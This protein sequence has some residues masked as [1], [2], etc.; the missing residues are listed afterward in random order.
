MNIPAFTQVFRSLGLLLLLLPGLGC[1]VACDDEEAPSGLV[2]CEAGAPEEW[3][4]CYEYFDKALACT[5]EVLWKYH[6]QGR[7]EVEDLPGWALPD[8]RDGHPVIDDVRAHD[9]PLGEGDAKGRLEE[10]A[11]RQGL[12][13]N[14]DEMTRCGESMTEAETRELVGGGSGTTEWGAGDAPAE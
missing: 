1:L 6:A 9:A 10:W 7:F 2:N 11:K 5:L 12:P 3:D 13:I 8:E 14:H 4:S